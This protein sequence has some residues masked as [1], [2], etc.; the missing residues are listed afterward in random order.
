MGLGEREVLTMPSA[1]LILG[2]MNG[3]SGAT[4]LNGAKMDGLE[5]FLVV[6]S[7]GK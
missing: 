3:R 4:A 2:F 7:S 5:E 1:I 6:T